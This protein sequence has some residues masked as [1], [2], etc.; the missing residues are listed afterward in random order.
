M[1]D[2]SRQN[3]KASEVE[4]KELYTCIVNLAIH[5]QENKWQ[6]ITV[7]ILFNT[8]LFLAW[9]TIFAKQ[10]NSWQFI[11]ALQVFPILG[12]LS[13]VFWLSLGEDYVSASNLFSDL[14]VEFERNFPPEC[15]QPL[16]RRKEQ[17][18]KKA[19][20]FCSIATSKWLIRLICIMFGVTHTLLI[21]VGCSIWI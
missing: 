21:I 5:G 3:S 19:Q 4:E 7:Y 20:S 10:N 6:T 9:S 13:S 8:I 2:K 1:C 17:R 16:T 11:V 18:D 15:I 14:A 12:I